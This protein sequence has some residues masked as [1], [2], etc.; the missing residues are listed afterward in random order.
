MCL[1]ASHYIVS[2]DMGY[3]LKSNATADVR[4]CLLC[5][6][7]CGSVMWHRVRSCWPLKTDS[8]PGSVIGL[9]V[10]ILI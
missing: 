2:N 8:D 4:V 7:G 1:R 6:D 10:R 9:A 3:D 5:E